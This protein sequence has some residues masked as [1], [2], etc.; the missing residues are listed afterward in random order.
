MATP[1]MT[2]YEMRPVDGIL[3]LQSIVLAVRRLL[4]DKGPISRD[5]LHAELENE[6][7]FK[8]AEVDLALTHVKHTVDENDVFAIY[9]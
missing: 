5:D 8:P 4:Q 9:P 6:S 3:R 7:Q 1:T 2:I